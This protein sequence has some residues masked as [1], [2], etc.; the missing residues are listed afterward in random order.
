MVWWGYQS[1]LMVGATGGGWC[2]GLLLMLHTAGGL[3]EVAG[4]GP[5]VAVSARPAQERL[6]KD[7]VVGCGPR[8]VEGLGELALIR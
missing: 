2:Q 7:G 4:Q 1:G 5:L 8:L 6:E 3:V